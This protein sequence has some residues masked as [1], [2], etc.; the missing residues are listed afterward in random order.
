MG[1]VV[2]GGVGEEGN[3]GSETLSSSLLKRVPNENNRV[4]IY[5]TVFPDGRNKKKL[6]VHIQCNMKNLHK[7]FAAFKHYI[8]V[9]KFTN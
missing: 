1:V 6:Q 5:T 2:R 4:E 7:N 9:K 8:Y 3:G